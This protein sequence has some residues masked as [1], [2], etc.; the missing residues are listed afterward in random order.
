MK[1]YPN[2][3]PNANQQQN[4]NQQPNQNEFKYK[5]EFKSNPNSNRYICNDKII[6]HIYSSLL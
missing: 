1:G 4:P 2:Q 5:K 6:K 3:Q